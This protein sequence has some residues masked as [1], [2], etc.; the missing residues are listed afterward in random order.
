MTDFQNTT[1]PQKRTL[2]VLQV[3]KDI[4]IFILHIME[5]NEAKPLRL[6]G[7]S[8]LGTTLLG[9]GIDQATNGRSHDEETSREY[10]YGGKNKNYEIFKDALPLFPLLAV[11]SSQNGCGGVLMFLYIEAHT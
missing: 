7:F 2:S 8:R 5:E 9:V 6:G 10:E 1:L 3:L 4:Q 11:L